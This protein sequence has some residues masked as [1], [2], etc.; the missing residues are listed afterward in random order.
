MGSVAQWR[1]YNTGSIRENK[2]R[3]NVWHSPDSDSMHILKLLKK[4]DPYKVS[5]H[6]DG[7]FGFL[8]SIK[9][10]DVVCCT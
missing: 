10:N 7:I 6:L 1:I 2:H 4:M 8:H 5:E 9:N 3:E